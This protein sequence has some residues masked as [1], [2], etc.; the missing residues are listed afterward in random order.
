MS[1]VEAPKETEVPAHLVASW[2]RPPQM[3]VNALEN[4]F[5][6]PNGIV[7]DLGT[8]NGRIARTIKEFN[9]HT[10]IAAIE[11][12]ESLSVSAY[13]QVPD[14]LV[15]NGDAAALPFANNVFDGATLVNTAHEVCESLD[16]K[17]RLAKFQTLCSEVSRTLKPGGK[18]V[19]FDGVMPE[20]N[21]L[22]L[23][24]AKTE[25]AQTAIFEFINAYMGAKVNIDRLPNGS[26][27]MGLQDLAIFATKFP[28]IGGKYWETERFQLYPFL[29][30]DQLVSALG[31]NMSILSVDHPPKFLGQEKLLE[32]FSFDQNTMQDF[33]PVQ[34]LISA[35]KKSN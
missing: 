11:L 23:M 3:V 16:E 21:A 19:L 33:P 10:T 25:F 6:R 15:V 9:P 1:T 28:Y 12:D 22:V 34:I 20:D 29:T 8:G 13:V 27:Q 18:L 31:K 26:F 2:P 17:V 35:Q 30:R 24:R 4:A 5:S 14:L 7:L 32:H